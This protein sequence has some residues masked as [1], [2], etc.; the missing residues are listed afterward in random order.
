MEKMSQVELMTVIVACEESGNKKLL[1]EAKEALIKKE[2]GEEK[3][4]QPAQDGVVV[5]A[6]H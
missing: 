2:K 5:G 6:E 4:L 3:C 1:K